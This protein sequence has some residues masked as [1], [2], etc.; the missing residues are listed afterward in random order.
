ARSRSVDDQNAAN[1]VLFHGLAAVIETGFERDGDD[2]RGHAVASGQLQ[3]VFSRS[4]RAT[5]NV[6]IGHDA[7]GLSGAP[8]IDDRDRT[9]VVV[10]EQAGDRR[11]ARFGR[12][13]GGVWSHDLT[14]FHSD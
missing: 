4:D 8:A 10:D 6:P 1:P 3:S 5:G 13:T 2:G 11:Q 14:D 12:A 9:A 7:E